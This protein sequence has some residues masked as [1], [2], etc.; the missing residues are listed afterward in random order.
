MLPSYWLQRAFDV[1]QVL[2]DWPVLEQLVREYHVVTQAA[3][4]PEPLVLNTLSSLSELHKRYAQSG[5]PD[6]NLQVLANSIIE[7]TA[8]PFDIPSTQDGHS[9]HTLFTGRQAR[10]EI[11]GFVYALAGKASLLDRA[12]NRFQE[13]GRPLSR[14]EFARRMLHASDTALQ[15]CKMLTPV[16]DLTI[17]LLYENLLLASMVN[18]DLSE[19]SRTS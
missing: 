19:F 13:S 2:I 10:L 9:F 1:L 11:I 8:C 18:G 6:D 17:W 16:N 12:A 5:N 3:V 14:V 15:L 4:I 7:N